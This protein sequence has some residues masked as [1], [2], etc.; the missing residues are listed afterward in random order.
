MK[1]QL[2]WRI[3]R[4]E[5]EPTK[6]LDAWMVLEVPFDGADRPWTRHFV[7]FRREGCKGQVSMPVEVFDP[8]H[9]RGV[10]RS[11][12]VYELGPLPGCNGDAFAMWGRWK[13]VNRIADERDVT[14]EVV[15][16]LGHVF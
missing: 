1:P 5:Q 13:Y 9:R 7:G 14:D 6:T 15:E 12:Q 10:T 4:I 16:D 8:V 2:P 3:G 11:G